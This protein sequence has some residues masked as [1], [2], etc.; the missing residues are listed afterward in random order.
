MIEV[1]GKVTN[2]PISILIDLGE[3][4]SYI[5]PKVLDIFNLMKRKLNGS[6][7]VQVAT[8]TK[9]MINEV[10]KGFP[11]DLS[12]VNINVDMNIIP[13]GSYDILIGMD[14]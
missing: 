8:R 10:V 12:Q 13:L 5:Y 2:Q 7:L 4:H 3:I 1:E 14:W 6:W 11:I 9:R